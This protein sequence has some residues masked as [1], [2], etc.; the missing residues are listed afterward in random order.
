MNGLRWLAFAPAVTLHSTLGHSKGWS[1]QCGCAAGKVARMC[2]SIL[3][4]L[5]HSDQH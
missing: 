5:F 2:L 1:S 4:A 3:C